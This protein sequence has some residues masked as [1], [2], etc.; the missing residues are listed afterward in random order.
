MWNGS[1][2]W[3]LEQRKLVSPGGPTW[4][5]TFT[6]GVVGSDGTTV[7]GNDVSYAAPTYGSFVRAY[8]AKEVP[9][10]YADYLYID[11]GGLAFKVNEESESFADALEKIPPFYIDEVTRNKVK[12]LNDIQTMVD[13]STFIHQSEKPQ[14]VKDSSSFNPLFVD[15]ILKYGLEKKEISNRTWDGSGHYLV[16]GDGTTVV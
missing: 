16:D 15:A 12:D 8:R 4:K 1:E 3:F 10:R 9:E 7:Q 13:Y 2:Q 11:R 14:K 6:K 5:K